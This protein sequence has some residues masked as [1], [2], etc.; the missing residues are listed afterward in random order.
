MQL[1]NLSRPRDIPFTENE[2]IA[3]LNEE[4]F[5]EGAKMPDTLK[6]K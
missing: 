6:Y 3:E 4:R 1:H 5:P 2:A